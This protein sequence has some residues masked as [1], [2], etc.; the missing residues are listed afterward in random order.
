MQLQHDRQITISA[1]GSRKA[2]QWPAQLIWWSDFVARLAVPVRGE[3][4]LAEYMRLPKS[5]Q[6]DL[7]DVGGFVGGKRGRQSEGPA[8]YW[9]YNNKWT[10]RL[11][12]G[13]GV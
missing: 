11:M 6:D 8:I 12:I 10:L 13:K 3:E 5:R 4:A 1:A 2:T 9:N 7:K